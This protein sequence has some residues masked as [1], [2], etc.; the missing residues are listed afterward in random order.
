MKN[1]FIL[2]C[3][4][5]TLIFFILSFSSLKAQQN[6]QIQQTVYLVEGLSNYE[7]QQLIK[8]LTNL[9]QPIS[10]QQP[11]NEKVLKNMAATISALHFE[12]A[13]VDIIADIIYK[14]YRA[15]INGAPDVYVQDLALVG[16]STK[17]S[18]KQLEK[19]AKG[20]EKL[21]DKHIDPL[22][23]EEFISYGLYN[24]WNGE[25][26]EYACQGLI[27]GVNQKLPA[28]KLALTLIIS[29]DQQIQTASATQIVNNAINFLKTQQEQSPREAQRQ[30]I[31]YQALQKAIENEIPR[32]IAEEIYFT[33]I[34]DEW[35]ADVINAVNEGLIRGVKQGLSAEKLATS[36]LVRLAQV[37]DV[38]SPEKLV[39]EEI[40]FIASLEKKQS[41]LI[42]EDQKKYKRKPVPPDYSQQSYLQPKKP[43]PSTKAPS[44]LYNSAGRPAINQQLM[45]QSIQ[46]YLGPPPTPYHWGGT[47]KSGIDCSGFVLRLYQEQG[48]Y[49]PRTS[50]RQFLVGNPV[51]GNLQFGDLVFFSKYG[52]AYKVTHVGLYIGGDKFIHSSASRGVTISSLNKRYYR[53][54]YKGA[55][56]IL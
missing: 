38:Q 45:W 14:A 50:S 20:I 17:L 6:I 52:P 26:I 53:I 36:L 25:T 3:F 27:D 12:Q 32:T 56:R 43:T 19:A 21:M 55:K 22:V 5:I 2:S 39:N 35:S 37:E 11:L 46:E 16:I 8:E 15:E 30:D 28:K 7:Q 1:S 54:R 29:I 34:E 10:E 9:F 40:E 4:Q 48:I 49:L 44:G 23:T 42:R 24:N 51:V 13:S 41:K 18:A 47:S 33:A 31:A